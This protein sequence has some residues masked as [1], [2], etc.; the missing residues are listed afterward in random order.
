MFK[1]KSWEYVWE[2]T[3]KV[4]DNGGRNIKLEQTEFIDMG[5]LRRYYKFNRDDHTGKKEEKSMNGWLKHQKM[6]G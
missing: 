1:Q 4:L 5:P 2:L 6:A 3:L